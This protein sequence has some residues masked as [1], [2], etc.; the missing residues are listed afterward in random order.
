M[1]FRTTSVLMNG[2]LLSLYLY[3][4]LMKMISVFVEPFANALT[5]LCVS[6]LCWAYWQS[7][8]GKLMVIVC[9]KWL[10]SYSFFS[11]FYRFHGSLSIEISNHHPNMRIIRRKIALLLGQ[12]ISEVRFLWYDMIS[13]NHIWYSLLSAQRLGLVVYFIF[14]LQHLL[15]CR[16]RATLGNWSTALWLDCCRIMT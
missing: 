4:F 11:I 1:N 13:E 15:L 12:W 16:S 3:E 7:I 2:R 5:C 6:I 9:S 14:G 8:I 10:H